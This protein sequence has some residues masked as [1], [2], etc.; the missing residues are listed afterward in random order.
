MMFL[1]IFLSSAVMPWFAA[2]LD[3]YYATLVLDYLFLG[4]FFIIFMGKRYLD[5]RISPLLI[6]LFFLVAYHIFYQI[7]FDMGAGSGGVVLVILLASVFYLILREIPDQ[8]FLEKGFKFLSFLFAIHGVAII[9]EFF[10]LAGGYG[11][12][13][14][15]LGDASNVTPYKDYNSAMLMQSMGY[16]VFGSNSLLLGSQSASMLILSGLIWFVKFGS[17]K[18]NFDV[19]LFHKVAGIIMF[20]FFPF[21]TSM[22]TSIISVCLVATIV[23]L[24]RKSVFRTKKFLVISAIVLTF[25]Y[26]KVLE[27]IFFRIQNQ[28]DLFIYIEA[29]TNPI[30]WFLTFKPA[31]QLFGLGRIQYPPDIDT[32]FGLFAL[33]IQIGLVP[34]L[35]LLAII[36]ERVWRS[37]QV[38]RNYAK[39]IS[40]NDGFARIGLVSSLLVILFC[41]S[42]IHYTAAIELGG[43]Q[44]FAFFIAIMISSSVRMKNKIKAR[45]S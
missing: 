3:S 30:I 38:S 11:H 2:I 10:L 39:R 41:M 43:R 40:D 37:L 12:V 8:L 13:L 7:L 16:N 1:F 23:M 27:L 26:S 24:V 9:V 32:D 31:E 45:I 14:V 19:S 29:F 36:V 44:M 33:V 18:S 25:A 4:Y 42:L 6:L 17:Y 5:V 34:V 22:T 35:V 15:E 28:S 21:V 20:L